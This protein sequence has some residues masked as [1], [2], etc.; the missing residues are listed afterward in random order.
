MR[1][2]DAIALFGTQEK[3]AEALGCAQSSVAEWKPDRIPLQRALQI[4]AIKGVDIDLSL[5][6]ITQQPSQ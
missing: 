3:L 4:Q 1:R 6:G 5:Y 2:D